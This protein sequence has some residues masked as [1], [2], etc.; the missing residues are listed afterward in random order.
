MSFGGVEKELL[1]LAG[2]NRY[3]QALFV[4]TLA[5]N[6]ESVTEQTQCLQKSLELIG[7]VK[8]YQAQAVS[9]MLARSEQYLCHALSGY[10]DECNATSNDSIKRLGTELFYQSFID[11]ADLEAESKNPPA[12]LLMKVSSTTLT[13]KLLGY[14]PRVSFKVLMENP[15]KKNVEAMVLYG[16]QVRGEGSVGVNSTECDN[17]G[18]RF[19][20]NSIVEVK[21]LGKNRHYKFCCAAYDSGQSM[22]NKPSEPTTEIVTGFP[23]SIHALYFHVGKSAFYLRNFEIAKTALQETLLMGLAKASD[24]RASMCEYVIDQSACLQYSTVEIQYLG[25]AIYMFA[26]SDFFIFKKKQKYSKRK[27]VA[28]TQRFL[29]GV[30]DLLVLGCQVSGYCKDYAGVI[31]GLL[32]GYNLCENFISKSHLP[33]SLLALLVKM[34]VMLCAVPGDYLTDVAMDFSNRLC[35]HIVQGCFTH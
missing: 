10:F 33:R 30:V 24:A 14:R 26:L 7:K 29:L 35:I 19:K 8:V 12:P 18:V 17:T 31:R 6:R 23:L 3:V 34:H 28:H 27:T 21:R 20:P 4:A 15:E 16:K 22:I 9:A 5:L 13:F 11:N 1:K 25:D 2:K 32:A